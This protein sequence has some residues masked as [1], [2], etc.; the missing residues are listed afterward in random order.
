MF[1]DHPKGLFVLAFANMGER[2]G[3][4]TMLAI[5]A[6]YI[7]AKFGLSSA[8]TSII[9]SSF[10]ALVYFLPLLGGLIADKAIGYGK[11]IALGIIVMFSGYLLLTIPTKPDTAGLILM[12]V[13]LFLIAL[14][15]GFFKGNLQALTGNLYDEA[16]Y[17]KK[18]DVAFSIFYMCINIGAFFAPNAADMICNGF[19]KADGLKYDPDIPAVALKYSRYEVRD[20]TTFALG[21]L[22]LAKKENKE[23]DNPKKYVAKMKKE[24]DIIYETEKIKFEKE[25][26]SFASVS[27]NKNITDV[28]KFAEDYVESLSK[29]YNW[30]F[31][32]A[33]FSLVLS[34]VIFLGFRRLYKHVDFTEKQK[35][36]IESKKAEVI[37]LTKEQTRERF[38]A[39]FLV[40]FVVIFF[41]MSFH[42]NGLCMNFFAR[43]YT[44][45]AVD[46]ITRIW[47]DLPSMLLIIVA[48]Y[49]FISLFQQKKTQNRMIAAIA[50]IGGLLGIVLLYLSKGEG[51]LAIT[52][53][54]F[55]QFNPFFIVV[56]TPVF[57]SMFAW[58]NKK[59]MEPSAP[60]KIGF[61]MIIAAIGFIILMLGSFGLPSPGDL[62][63]EASPIRVSSYWLISTYFVLTIAELFLSPMGISFVSKVAPPKYKGLMQGGWFAATATGNYLVGV[64]GMF[65]EKL[66]LWTFWLIL[67]ICCTLSAAFIF[68][69]LK[70]LE[71]VAK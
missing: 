15:T 17:S 52:P 33:C 1:K 25:L 21:I 12:F 10:L 5:L 18:R 68:S 65:W 43:D 11:T 8:N 49:G 59:D 64:M 61:G 58:L 19:M 69:V 23:I 9:Y 3:Y 45:K 44:E 2:F 27:L 54:I 62:Q 6:L 63:G 40:F 53:Q 48:F 60:R 16:K 50:L 14:G 37:E 71:K 4:Y 22:D 51:A 7:Q 67:V 13:A 66:P 31:S 41:W 34:M 57:V 28:K 35:S 36:K 56:M 20:S 32:V 70:R 24:Q 55:Q 39:L 42:Q 26:I 29:S 47:F 46:G 38:I 30:S